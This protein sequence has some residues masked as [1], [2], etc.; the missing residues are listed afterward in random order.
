M[1]EWFLC[2]LFSLCAS[3]P[4]TI[5]KEDKIYRMSERP[6]LCALRKIEKDENSED[7]GWVCVY[8]HPKSKVDDRVSVCYECMCPKR[9]YCD[10]RENGR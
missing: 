3:E 1:V 2:T 4:T 9:V 6:Y 8:D 10:N 7:M 5:I